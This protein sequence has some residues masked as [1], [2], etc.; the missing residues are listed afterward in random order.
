[1]AKTDR[2]AADGTGE[3]KPSPMYTETRIYTTTAGVEPV[4]ALLMRHGI[5]EVSVEDGNDMR[6][7]IEAKDWLGWDYIDEELMNETRGEAVITF[8][9]ENTGVWQAALTEIKTGLMMLKADE[10]YGEYGEGADF[11]R[12]YAESE[13]LDEGWKEKCAK[14]F[15][16]FRATDRITVRPVRD[17]AGEPD[18]KDGNDIVISIEPGMAF[19]TGTHETTAMC[20]EEIER[21]VRPGVRMLDIGAGSGILSIAAVLLGA[22]EVT[23]VEYDADAS[24]SA[25]ANFRANGVAG[26]VSL[27]EGDIRDI[28]GMR[29]PYDI[30]AAN[31]TSGLLA[32][33]VN[34]L[35]AL[36]ARGGQLIVSG[37]LANEAPAMK[38]LIAHAGFT[39]RSSETRGEWL[40]LC[41]DFL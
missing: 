4:T 30:V 31:I 24:A 12:L 9:T 22:E 7:V 2:A 16:T 20:L 35:P 28:S 34:T 33:I 1:M 11:G 21:A 23:A 15:E 14:V 8:Y 5:D 3:G 25:L 17:D 40:A 26:R 32:E 27:I 39:V 41:A 38:E 13:P 29:G 18:R 19:G 37:L 36:T 6:A 10:Q